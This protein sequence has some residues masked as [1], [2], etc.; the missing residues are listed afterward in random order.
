M[1]FRPFFGYMLGFIAMWGA[2]GSIIFF[3]LFKGRFS[4]KNPDVEGVLRD[5]DWRAIFFYISLFML[6]GGLE[7]SGVIKV[8][9]AAI[10]PMIKRA[11]LWAAR[12]STG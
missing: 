5:L 3:E 6:V 4:V 10:T 2:I 1:A 12:S 9:T 11:S 8:L 7:H